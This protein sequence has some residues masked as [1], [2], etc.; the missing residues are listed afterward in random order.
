MFND[1]Q[2]KVLRLGIPVVEAAIKPGSIHRRGS[3]PK[4]PKPAQLITKAKE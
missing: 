4:Q 3:V 1:I 2:E